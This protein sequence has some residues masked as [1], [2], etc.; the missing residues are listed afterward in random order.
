MTTQLI[1]VV[2]M[3]LNMALVLG[4]AL[5]VGGIV[6]RI[7]KNESTRRFI[8]ILASVLVLGSRMD[9]V[10]AGSLT[11][12]GTGW[13]ASWDDPTLKLTWDKANNVLTK[14][15]TFMSLDPISITFEDKAAKHVSLFITV[16]DTATNKTD[17]EWTDFIFTLSDLKTVGGTGSAFHPASTHFHTHEAATLTSSPLIYEAGG[18][19]TEPSQS[20]IFL[21]LG[22]PVKVG[23]DLTADNFKI[24]ATLAEKFLFTEQPSGSIPEP[25]SLVLLGLGIISLIG[26]YNV[27]LRRNAS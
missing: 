8:I 9:S 2:L 6:A 23:S 22:K 10:E 1:S 24:H 25:S 26:Y 13:A 19:K 20:F 7:R 4:V 17:R 5:M 27:S 11:L 16:K 14:T 15:V 21:G 3:I 12:D 18:D